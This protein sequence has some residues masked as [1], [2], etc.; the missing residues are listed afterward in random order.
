MGGLVTMIPEAYRPEG[1]ANAELHQ[2]PVRRSDT[3]DIAGRL[4]FL[5]R[6]HVAVIPIRSRPPGWEVAVAHGT[7]AL[8]RGVVL[9]LSDWE[10]QRALELDFGKHFSMMVEE[11]WGLT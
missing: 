11:A 6:I 9:H 1:S 10:L 3:A 4:F 8:K 5:P 2:L 7:D